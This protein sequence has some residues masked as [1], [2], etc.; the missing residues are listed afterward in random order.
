[1]IYDYEP[2]KV[3]FFIENAEFEGGYKNFKLYI[4]GKVWQLNLLLNDY[5]IEYP[6]PKINRVFDL[7]YRSQ[8][9]PKAFGI[10]KMALDYLL[11]VYDNETKEYKQEVKKIKACYKLIDTYLAL[12]HLYT[13]RR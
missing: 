12:Y 13:E 4:K 6:I 11:S 7:I 10:C 1:M 5:F 9:A 2:I 3:G 8:D